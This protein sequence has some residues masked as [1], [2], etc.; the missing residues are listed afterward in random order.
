MKR[1]IV[2]FVLLSILAGSAVILYLRWTSPM[3][4]LREIA[5]AVQQRDAKQLTK[6]VDVDQISTQ[7]VDAMSA[8]TD[9]L[10]FA[11]TQNMRPT[12]IARFKSA[13]LEG[14][15]AGDLGGRTFAGLPG[16][17]RPIRIAKTTRHGKVADVDVVFICP[18]HPDEI[19]LTLQLRDQGTYWQ[20]FRI[21][22]FV[23]AATH[24]SVLD[25]R[26][27]AAAL[28]ARI[29]ADQQARSAVQSQLQA[30][31][32]NATSNPTTPEP[33]RELRKVSKIVGYKDRQIQ[34]PGDVAF[35][36]AN[37]NFHIFGCPS[38]TTDMETVNVH[39]L[40]V[41]SVPRSPDCANRPL[42]YETRT[43]HE[44]ITETAME[45]VPKP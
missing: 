36:R 6:Y 29:R 7:A 45:W 20:L 3:H 18:P 13:L 37:R 26:A 42:P 24:I 4:S 28:D 43:L 1:A 17:I 32:V 31:V 35:D 21:A 27:A 11:V 44:P 34:V 8:S 22:N 33:V 19:T 30:V 41:Q 39:T 12:L 9:G 15:E 2:L 40:Q 38:V 25:T 5:S 14:V 23:E 16:H 10:A